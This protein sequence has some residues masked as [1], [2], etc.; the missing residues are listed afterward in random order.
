MILYAATNKSTGMVYIGITRQTFA[1]RMNGHRYAAMKRAS[2]AR[3]HA[4]IRECGWAAFS[5]EALATFET[6]D[7]LRDAERRAI[8]ERPSAL[9]YN[10]AEGGA[11]N[12]G[13]E[14]TEEVR[15]RISEGTRNSTHLRFG[16]KHQTRLFHNRVGVPHTEECKKRISAS[17]KLA[18]HS[19]RPRKLLPEQYPEILARRKAGESFKKLGQAFGVRPETVFYFCKRQGA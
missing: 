16:L 12:A 9:L 4:A 6:I 7:A 17:M 5:W 13:Y 10:M 14:F 8:S 1:A 3:F 19:N 18:D 11:G 15:K 2:T